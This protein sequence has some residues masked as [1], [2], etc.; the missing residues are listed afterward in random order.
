M[1]WTLDLTARSDDRTTRTGD[2]ASRSASSA[3]RSADWCTVERGAG[4]ADRALVTDGPRSWIDRTPHWNRWAD[5]FAVSIPGLDTNGTGTAR[6]RT[7]KNALVIRESYHVGTSTPLPVYA[8]PLIR[9][10]NHEG[11]TTRLVQ[12]VRALARCDTVNAL[13]GLIET[14][15]RAPTSEKE[16][17]TEGARSPLLRSLV[18]HRSPVVRDNERVVPRRSGSGPATHIVMPPY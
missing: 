11:Q 12:P 13:T 17:A 15:G 16:S 2:Q 4:G 8:P 9:A 1:F 6:R 18:R 3:R 7:G 14:M 10:G 5:H